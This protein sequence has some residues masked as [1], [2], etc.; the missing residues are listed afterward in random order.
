M[1][2]ESLEHLECNRRFWNG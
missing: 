1:N 2:F